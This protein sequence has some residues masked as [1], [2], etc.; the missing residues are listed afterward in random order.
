MGRSFRILL[1]S[2][3]VVQ[4]VL[5]IA[6]AVRLPAVTELW[7]SIMPGATPLS[8]SFVGSIFAAAAASTLWCLAASAEDG[9]LVGVALDYLTIFIPITIF[10]FQLASAEGST[11]VLIFAVLCAIGV[12][13]GAMLFS[14]SRNVS[15]RDLR[16]QPRLVRV[17]F[18]F[19]IVAL[20]IVG[21]AMVLKAPNIMPWT[22][23]T[24]ESVIYGWM[25]LGAAVY[26][27]YSLLRPSWA[28]SAG[29]LA[30]FLAYD[31]VLVF[32][33][34]ARFG[35]PIPQQFLLGHIIYTV[36]V[37]YSAALA[38]FYLFMNPETRLIRQ[39]TLTPSPNP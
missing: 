3:A 36:V 29:Q 22:I 39:P 19:F 6:F 13:F 10:A 14:S 7:A 12:L 38:I 16:P 32:P 24:G 8:V 31:L 25:F 11:P 15:I 18:G 2:V 27:V 35:S 28:N 9:A 33:F 5:G 4:A 17:S 20:L 1:F 37:I 30:G 21:G 23:S 26:F 34:L